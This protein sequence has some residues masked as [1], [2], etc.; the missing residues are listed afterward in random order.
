M[1]LKLKC[2]QIKYLHNMV[3]I[4]INIVDIEKS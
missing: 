3:G 4:N 2:M 1:Y